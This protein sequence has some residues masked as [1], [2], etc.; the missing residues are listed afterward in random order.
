[1]R[2]CNGEILQQPDRALGTE[3]AHRAWI[4]KIETS[5]VI[6]YSDKSEFMEICD[7]WLRMV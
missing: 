7:A 4:I 3:P 5:E 1:M 6:D 2:P